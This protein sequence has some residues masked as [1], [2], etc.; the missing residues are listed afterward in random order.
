MAGHRIHAR[1]QGDLGMRSK[2][3]VSQK[4]LKVKKKKK[5]N[6]KH[7]SNGALKKTRPFLKIQIYI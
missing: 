6:F 7:E 5:I 2:P 3:E 4:A 1:Q